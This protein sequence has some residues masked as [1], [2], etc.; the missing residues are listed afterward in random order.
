M[1]S[2]FFRFFCTDLIKS[3]ACWKLPLTSNWLMSAQLKDSLL[4]GLLAVSLVNEK[5]C[6]F[7]DPLA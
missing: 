3:E 7:Y 4:L 1:W 6:Y 5:D 2:R